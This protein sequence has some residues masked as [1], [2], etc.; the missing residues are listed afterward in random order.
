VLS[1][2]RPIVADGQLIGSGGGR[3]MRPVA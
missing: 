2:G 1:R 3:L